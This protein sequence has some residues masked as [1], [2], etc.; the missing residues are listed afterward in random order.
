[1]VNGGS[2]YRSELEYQNQ[3]YQYSSF[4]GD[5]LKDSHVMNG[6]LSY[7]E[8]TEEKNEDKKC[9]YLP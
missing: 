2:K 8:F 3:S 5:N 9:C 1:M 6:K 7:S 4:A